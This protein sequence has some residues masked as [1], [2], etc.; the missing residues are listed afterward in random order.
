[1]LSWQEWHY[2]GCDDP[3]TTGS[4]DKQA[5]VLD[6]AKPPSGSNLKTV[7]LDAVTRPY[8]RTVAGTPTGWSFD[9]TSRRFTASWTARRAGARGGSFGAGA[10]SEIAVPRR[11]YPDGYAPDVRGGSILSAPG[12]A[13]LRVAACTGAD[14]VKVTVVRGAAPAQSSCAGPAARGART[15]LRVSLRP[16]TV[17]AGRRE[18]VRITVR[19]GR[20]GPLRG[21][22]VRLG[23]KR[24]VTDRRGRARLTVRFRRPGRR[25]AVARARGYRAGRASL[26]VSRRVS[27]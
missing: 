13:L 3:T 8:P 21:A 25:V 14:Q 10:V 5:I 12:A 15:R 22:V 2:C 17:R 6:P 18:S 19:A 9:P 26:R 7:T 24:G 23:G 20:S 1:M 16:R 4:G 11:Q 27:A